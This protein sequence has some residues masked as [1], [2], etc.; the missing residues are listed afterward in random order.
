MHVNSSDSSETSPPAIYAVDAD[1]QGL[2]PT[3]PID[4][5]T[6]LRALAEPLAS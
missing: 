2:A 1:G 6:I 5:A 3:Q 4:M